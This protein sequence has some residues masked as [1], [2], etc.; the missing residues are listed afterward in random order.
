MIKDLVLLTFLK[1]FCT[2]Q[3]HNFYTIQDTLV[4][5]MHGGT[6]MYGS[7]QCGSPR[8]IGETHAYPPMR[9]GLYKSYIIELCNKHIPKVIWRI[10]F[11]FFSFFLSFLFIL[12]I[13]YVELFINNLILLLL[14]KSKNTVL[15]SVIK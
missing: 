9:L 10:L 3:L 5:S 14:L 2:I 11:S 1:Y 12:S 8:H 6:H 7:R 4:G 13:L 15:K